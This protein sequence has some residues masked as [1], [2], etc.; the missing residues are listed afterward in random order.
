MRTEIQQSFCSRSQQRTIQ[1]VVVVGRYRLTLP[2]TRVLIPLLVAAVT[3]L[4]ALLGGQ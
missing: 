3:F 1:L 2:Q 4:F